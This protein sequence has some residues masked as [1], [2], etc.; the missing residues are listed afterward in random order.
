[1][2]R[3]RL[4][5]LVVTR[6]SGS[7]LACAASRLVTSS[8]EAKLG[9]EIATQAEQ[10]FRLVQVPEIASDVEAVGARLVGSSESV[11]SRSRT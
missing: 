5:L 11:L 4:A 9:H 6:L 2:E 8:G 3:R 1:M 10:P 7:L